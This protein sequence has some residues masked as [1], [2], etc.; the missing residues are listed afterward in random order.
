[1]VQRAIRFR[2]FNKYLLSIFSSDSPSDT[3]LQILIVF[4]MF[5]CEFIKKLNDFKSYN[6][7]D[8]VL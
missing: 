5:C 4:I 8:I 2:P 3:D 1:M 6:K 7:K